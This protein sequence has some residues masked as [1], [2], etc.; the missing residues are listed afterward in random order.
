MA[1]HTDECAAQ[2][3]QNRRRLTARFGAV[4]WL[5]QTHS[6]TVV[7]VARVSSSAL[8]ADAAYTCAGVSLAVLTADCLPVIF[9]SATGDEYAVAHAGWRGLLN[10]VLLNTLA[11]FRSKTVAAV[12]GPSIS[13][14]AYQVDAIFR[15]RFIAAWGASAS[16]GFQPDGQAHFKANLQWLATNQLTAAGCAS[17][18]NTSLCSRQNTQFFSYRRDKTGGRMATVI[19]RVN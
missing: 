13:S 5:H 8:P 6:T 3:L 9:Y 10:G 15:Q 17:V 2:A 1:I 4:Q 18:T 7:D 14:A 11:K 12:I 16:H 19:G